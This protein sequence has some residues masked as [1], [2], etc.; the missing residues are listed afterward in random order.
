M[1]LRPSQQCET[2]YTVPV[3][4]TVPIWYLQY[5]VPNPL[6]EAIL[7]FLVGA[8]AECSPQL[9][10][11]RPERERKGGSAL[12][13]LRAARR[14]RH[15]DHRHCRSEERRPSSPRCEKRSQQQASEPHAGTA[16]SRQPGPSKLIAV[17]GD[18][19]QAHWSLLTGDCTPVPAPAPMSIARDGDLPCTPVPSPATRHRPHQRIPIRAPHAGTTSLVTAHTGGF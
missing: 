7:R 3:V 9:K 15:T 11:S 1:P 13:R 10:E 6:H 16:D 17:T 2:Q 14:E 19:R 4:S 12:S 5:N 18:K 8:R